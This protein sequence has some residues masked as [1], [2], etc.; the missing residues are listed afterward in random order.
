M[1]DAKPVKAPLATHFRLST[2]LSP[3]I[4]EEKKYMSCVPY[5]SAVESIM[6]AMMYTQSDISHAVSVMS[7]YMDRPGKGYWQ[8]L[9]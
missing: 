7:R 8:A 2:D 9:K 4:D 3:Q 6:H 1:L 5:T